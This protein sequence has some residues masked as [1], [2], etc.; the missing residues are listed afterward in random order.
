MPR[1]I[2]ARYIGQ[3]DNQSVAS[4]NFNNVSYYGGGF[5]PPSMQNSTSTGKY[6]P[7]KYAQNSNLKYIGTIQNGEMNKSN[8]FQSNKVMIG[9]P[10]SSTTASR[11]P[12]LSPNFQINPG[13]ERRGSPID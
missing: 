13:Y 12:G 3:D 8:Y 7:L 1:A 9:T 10:Q 11:Q 2:S 6:D 4:G 5:F